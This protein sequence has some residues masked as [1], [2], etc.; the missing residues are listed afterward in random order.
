MWQSDSFSLLTGV[1]FLNNLKYQ[2]ASSPAIVSKHTVCIKS[3]KLQKPGNLPQWSILSADDRMIK[4]PVSAES[5][6]VELLIRTPIK[7]SNIT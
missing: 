2:L 5:I 6:K 4:N 7:P 3:N 1:L